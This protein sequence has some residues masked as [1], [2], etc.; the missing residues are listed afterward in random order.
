MRQ[1]INLET[2]STASG[3]HARM[4]ARRDFQGARRTTATPA[5]GGLRRF[6][7]QRGPRRQARAMFALHALY[8]SLISA[9]A[10]EATSTWRRWWGGGGLGDGGD[11]GVGLGGGGLGGGGDGGGGDGYGGD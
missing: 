5:T 1:A 2:A 3:H 8:R 11:G 9:R 6:V 10:D 4:G 7:T